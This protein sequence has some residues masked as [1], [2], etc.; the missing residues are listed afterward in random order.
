MSRAADDGP[1]GTEDKHRWECPAGHVSWERCNDHVWCHGCAQEVTHNP[2]AD[3]EWY[4]LHDKVNG[5]MVDVEELLDD[6]PEFSE[7][8]AY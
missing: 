1:T 3:P 8:S 5:E 2:D 6:W 7:V 4:R